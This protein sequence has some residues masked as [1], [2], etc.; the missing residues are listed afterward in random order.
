MDRYGGR[1]GRGGGYG[2]DRGGGGYGGRDG[3]G[4]AFRG[5]GGDRGDYGDRGGYGGGG[6]ERGGYGDRGGRG[7]Y[8]G[9]RGGHRGGYSGGR[10]GPRG[11]DRGGFGAGGGGGGYGGG[12]G[13]GRARG[14]SRQAELGTVARP[15][16]RTSLSSTDVARM[17]VHAAIE[18]EPVECRELGKQARPSRPGFGKAG[19]PMTIGANHFAVLCRIANAFHYDVNIIGLRLQQSQMGCSVSQLICLF[20]FVARLLQSCNSCLQH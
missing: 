4:G 19:R 2:D 20:V 17:Q 15:G 5:R 3:G 13:G 14:P 16:S 10:G 12:G 18:K 7:G 1:G 8:G 6:G 11:G 9:G